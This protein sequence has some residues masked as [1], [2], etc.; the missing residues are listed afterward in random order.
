MLAVSALR[1]CAQPVVSP[2]TKEALLVPDSLPTYKFLVSGHWYGAGTSRSGFPASTVLGNIERF[3][4]TGASFFLLTGDI[5][6]NTKSDQA[7]YAPSL[8]ERLRIPLFNAVGNHDLDGGFYPGLFGSTHMQWDVRTDRFIILDTERDDSN[9]SGDQLQMLETAAGDVEAGKVKRVFITSHRPIWSESGTYSS[10]FPGNT[11]SL[12]GSNYGA[13]VLPLLQRMLKHAEVYWIAGSMGGA[14]PASILYE[15][16]EPGLHYV[17]SAVRD[18]ARDA[19][20]LAEVSADSVHWE[21][22]SLTGKW[23]GP[24]EQYNAQWWRGH[25]AHPEGFE[26]KLLPYYFTSTITHRAFWIGVLTTLALMGTVVFLR[27]RRR[28]G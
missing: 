8:Y 6:Q 10:L 4:A 16:P 24:I 21:A 11:K 26:W 20:L 27:R 2:I 19:V 14:A 3:N 1:V 17:M 22:I 23:I 13:D 9:I 15:T 25:L 5:F 7:R 12:T 28:A 18:E